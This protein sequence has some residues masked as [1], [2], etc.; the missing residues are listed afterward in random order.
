MLPACHPLVR[1]MAV[2]LVMTQ[3][4]EIGPHRLK[5]TIVPQVL[6]QYTTLLLYARGAFYSPKSFL[7]Q[8]NFMHA[9]K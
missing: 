5:G 7:G 1:K 4:T 9:R 6:H 8:Q 3:S 2:V